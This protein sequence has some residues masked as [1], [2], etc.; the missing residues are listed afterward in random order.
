MQARLAKIAVTSLSISIVSLTLAAWSGGVEHSSRRWWRWAD[1]GGCTVPQGGDTKESSVRLDW[2]PGDRLD[3]ALPANVDYRPG[4]KGEAV[5]SGQAWLLEHVRLAAGRL[6]YEAGF[7]CAPGRLSVALTGP[8]VTNWRMQGSGR[9]NLDSIDQES[10]DIGIS[11]SGDVTASG[12]A[13]RMALRISGSG[14]AAMAKLA[15]KTA[16][17]RISGRGDADI[18]PQDEADIHI[19]G[20]GNVTLHGHPTRLQT[21]ISGSGRISE[22]P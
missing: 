10:L 17:L 5:I 9:L 21:R 8:A 19:S 20:S 14:S 7:D 22:A 6:A 3:I 4:P 11:G 2:E 16:E 1:F 15:L 18:A 12:T 13:G